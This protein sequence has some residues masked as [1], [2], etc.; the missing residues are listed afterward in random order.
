[1]AVAGF[2]CYRLPGRFVAKRL[3]KVFQTV[4]LDLIDG[5]KH[6]TQP[7]GRKPLLR[8]PDDVGLGK[9]D[10]SPSGISAEGHSHIDQFQKSSMIETRILLHV[11]PKPSSTPAK[12]VTHPRQSRGLEKPY[13]ADLLGKS[14]GGNSPFS[15]FAAGNGFLP[16]RSTQQISPVIPSHH[17]LTLRLFSSGIS[18]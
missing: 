18:Q 17:P 2:S 4:D 7:P 1:M 12:P 14:K 11:Q 10:Q 9:V 3:E 6:L 15:I 13:L 16:I 8:K 5:L